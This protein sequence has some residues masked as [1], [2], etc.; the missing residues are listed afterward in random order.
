MAL[1]YVGGNSNNGKANANL[2]VDLTSLS[3]GAASSPSNGDIIIAA[4]SVGTTGSVTPTFST[5]GYTEIASL[6]VSDSNSNRLLAGYKKMGASPD[7]SVTF[8]F[9]S[10]DNEEGVA[11]VVHVWRNVDAVV[12][13]VPSTTATGA[14]SSRPDAPSITPIAAAGATVLAIGGSAIDGNAVNRQIGSA[15]SGYSNFVTNY[16]TPQITNG[17][18]GSVGIA[19]KSWT[20]GAENPGIFQTVSGS[21]SSADSWCAITIALCAGRVIADG[22]VSY[23]KLD[24]SSGDA[25]DSV[26]SN[27]LTNNNTVT[28]S[29]GKIN[30]GADFGSS[31]TNKSLSTTATLG[32]DG[33]SITMAGWVKVAAQP[34]SNDNVRLFGHGNTSNKV[35]EQ[36]LYRDVS[37]TKRITFNRLRMNTANDEFSYDITLAV[38]TWYHIVFT[39][40]GSTV[41]GYING[42]SVGSVAS[43]GNGGSATGYSSGVY[44]AT[45]NGG[46]SNFLS[47]MIDEFGVWSRALSADEVSQLYG[48]QAGNQYPFTMPEAAKGFFN[49]L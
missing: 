12:L 34:P 32:I 43:S 20:S 37:G 4:V 41:R 45:S 11:A 10:G 36:L 38:G 18:F 9:T 42:A 21:S 40:D 14:D 2:T 35:A 26:G 19:S 24:E 27:T 22:I 8:A 33:G 5:S 3:G 30:N 31:N 39:Y 15:P 7:S 47:G 29:A 1:V 48:F 23:W 17:S 44:V 25:A 6:S 16:G 46:G 49:F 13:D 28:Y